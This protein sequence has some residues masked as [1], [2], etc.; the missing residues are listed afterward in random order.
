MSGL[1]VPVARERHIETG[2]APFV[3]VLADRALHEPARFG[4]AGSRGCVE[5]QQ[6]CHHAFSLR[7]ECKLSAGDEIENFRHSDNFDDHSAQS[8]AGER[9][10]GSTQRINCIRSAQHQQAA[11]IE[12]HLQKSAAGNLAIFESGKILPDPEKF[13]LAR[14]APQ[15]E[16]NC[17]SAGRSTC[18]RIGG[19]DFMQCAGQKATAQRGIGLRMPQ[20]C[21]P[22]APQ[23]EWW[24]M[25]K[26]PRHSQFFSKICHFLP[27][28]FS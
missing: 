6:Q 27:L 4:G 13:S 23:I 26:G 2:R 17:E 15:S 7:G 9:I 12:A 11:R 3:A 28:S 5:A 10:G 8:F 21:A 20:C 24:G 25:E 18:N 1:S 14:C 22:L 16:G 19:K